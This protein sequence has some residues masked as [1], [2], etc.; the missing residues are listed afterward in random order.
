MKSIIFL[1]FFI[2]G[3]HGL[4]GLEGKVVSFPT[5]TATSYVE[6]TPQ[7]EEE[8]E[9]FTICLRFNT[10]LTRSY[11]LF[12][13]ATSAYYNDIL[14]WS[15]NQRRYS[16]YV[17]NSYVSFTIPNGRSTTGWPHFC[18][19]WES[20]TGKAELWLNGK[21]L[22]T[23]TLRRGS[24]VKSNP[25]IIIGQEQDSFGGSFQQ[26][27]S[28]VGN[29][30]DVHMWDYVISSCK[31]KSARY[32]SSCAKGNLIDW[33]TVTF[34]KSGNVITEPKVEEDYY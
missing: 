17:H 6:L 14:L 32:G 19:T 30:T 22:G 11:S 2:K 23:K 16:I 28:F 10:S 33:D 34:H 13:F 9:A 4:T 8:L 31:I 20:D 1:L 12:S 29:I 7:H 18:G 26:S 3:L 25:S 15:N 21:S 27:Q 24:T 5:E